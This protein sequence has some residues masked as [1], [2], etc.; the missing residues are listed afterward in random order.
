MTSGNLDAYIRSFITPLPVFFDAMGGWHVVRSPTELAEMLGIK[1]TQMHANGVVRHTSTIL[2][3]V[4][5]K[6]RPAVKVRC[7]AWRASGMLGWTVVARF[8]LRIVG[9]HYRAEMVELLELDPIL[10]HAT[11]E[12]LPHRMPRPSLH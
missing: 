1:R 7:E 12:R 3:V 5:S 9:G 6:R 11:L 10:G 4:G 8:Y 2:D